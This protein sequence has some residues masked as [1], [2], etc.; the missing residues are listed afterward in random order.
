[1]IPAN[2]YC[3]IAGSSQVE[4]YSTC[5]VSCYFEFYC[6]HGQETQVFWRVFGIWIYLHSWKKTQWSHSVFCATLFSL[7]MLGSWK[8]RSS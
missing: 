6:C 4:T 1:L 8:L 7:L 3:V 5:R 2:C